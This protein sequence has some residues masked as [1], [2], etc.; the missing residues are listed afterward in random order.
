MDMFAWIGQ[1]YTLAGTA[2]AGVFVAKRHGRYG[3][4]ETRFDGK[5][6]LKDDEFYYSEADADAAVMSI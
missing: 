6:R 1:G 2:V 5:L 4:L 3:V